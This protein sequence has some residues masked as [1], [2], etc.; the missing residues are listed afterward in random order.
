M[1]ESFQEL[2]DRAKE[3]VDLYVDN[4]RKR[5]SKMNANTLLWLIVDCK[6]FA[7]WSNALAMI[8]EA[9]LFD[10]RFDS[11]IFDFIAE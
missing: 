5:R 6:R 8:D 9:R 1:S 7:V 4:I 3:E 11:E 10:E 2:K